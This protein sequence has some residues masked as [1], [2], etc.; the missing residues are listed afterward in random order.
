[1][2]PVRR[3]KRGKKTAGR[4]RYDSDATGRSTISANN[5][6]RVDAVDATTAPVPLEDAAG[7]AN[8]AAWVTKYR[9][10]GLEEEPRRNLRTKAV[11]GASLDEPLYF[12]ELPRNSPEVGVR[13]LD[14]EWGSC[15][16]GRRSSPT[17]SS[18][19]TWPR[20]LSLPWRAT[21]PASGYAAR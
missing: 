21:I 4:Q 1:M 9:T 11:D 6:Q 18:A 7:A 17:S 5:F 8:I 3:S 20:S 15:A 14:Y 13:K 16:Y 19:C 2:P 12:Y 10:G